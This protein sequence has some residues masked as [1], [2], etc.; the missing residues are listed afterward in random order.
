MKRAKEE[1]VRG[2]VLAEIKK[3]K[4]ILT[5]VWYTKKDIKGAFSCIN[6]QYMLFFYKSK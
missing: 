1:C 2:D 6:Y 5:R 3:R 4:A